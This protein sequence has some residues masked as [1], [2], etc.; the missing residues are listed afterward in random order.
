MRRAVVAVLLAAL[1]A[2]ACGGGAKASS[3]P[4]RGKLHYVGADLLPSEVLGLNVHDEHTTIDTKVTKQNRS[5]V[6]AIGLLSFRR[7]DLLQA[8]LQIS[9]LT[10]AAARHPDRFRSTVLQGV[11]GSAREPTPFRIENHKVY[12]TSG[13]QQSI[14]LWFQGKSLYLLTVRSDFKQPRT[15]LRE[16]VLKVPA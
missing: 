5:Y 16:I 12:L 8:T 11:L 9:R 6:D 7:G 3:K 15:L 14:A 10:N 1:T 4:S 2:T 13:D